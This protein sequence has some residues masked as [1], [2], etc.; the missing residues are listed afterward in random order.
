M[1]KKIYVVLSVVMYVIAVLILLFYLVMT[2]KI[3]FTTI[4]RLILL[5]GSCLFLYFGG[6]FLSKYLNNNKPMKIN[7]WIYFILYI[8]L[9]LTLT[10]FDPMYG[11]SFSIV[12]WSKELFNK[13]ISNS[14]NLIP[15]HTIID[16]ISKFNSLYD[17][18][19]IM[20]NL[21]GNL[22]ALMPM[23]IFLPLLFKK[24]RKLKIFY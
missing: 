15:F 22:I 7:L 1:K 6:F 18:K 13:Y 23:A 11:R 20:V 4:S 3:Q 14:F 10:L 5:C 24:T 9:L 2:F 17:T 8:I 16:Y 12:D 21:L 19:T